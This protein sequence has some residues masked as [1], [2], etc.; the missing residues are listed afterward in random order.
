MKKRNTMRESL[1]SEFC[2]STK[3]AMSA[4]A[5]SSE[6]MRKGDLVLTSMGPKTYLDKPDSS[7][8]QRI[9]ERLYRKYSPAL[10]GS[11]THTAI[12][13][14]SG[15]VIEARG[16][17]V[18]RRSLKSALK[19]IDG[20]MVVRPK[21]STKTREGAVEFAKKQVGKPYESE[22]FLGLQGAALVLPK[23][24]EKLLER[25]GTPDDTKRFTCANLAAASYVSQG[26]TPR[27]DKGSWSLTTSGDFLDPRTVKKVKMLGQTFTGKPVAGRLRETVKIGHSMELAECVLKEASIFA[28]ITRFFETRENKKSLRRIDSHFRS[29]DK[30]KWDNFLHHSNRKSFVKNLSRDGRSDEKLIMHADNMNRMQ[31]GKKLGTILG[32]TGQRYK[33]TKLRGSPRLGC[34]CKDWRYK[35]SVVLASAPDSEK[36]CRH[37]KQWKREKGLK[38]MASLSHPERRI[39]ERAPGSELEVE[40]IRSQLPGMRLKAGQ[41]YYRALPNGRG[42]VV[43]GDVGGRHVVKTVLGPSMRPPGRPLPISRSVN[44]YA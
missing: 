3:Q 2:E 15:D 19:N 35:R 34:T 14:G 16:D 38:K 23:K 37:I 43:I 27:V 40:K 18:Q 1:F 20:A 17:G 7:M 22:A 41:T 11:Y 9:K 4:S 36:D 6:G 44:R 8:F 25:G 42:F 32:A 29:D 30:N 28:P 13:A 12:Y 21:A 24:M 33:I 39:S 5:V 26:F 31:S 10:Q